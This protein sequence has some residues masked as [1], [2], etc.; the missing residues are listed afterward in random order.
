MADEAIL[1]NEGDKTPN[2]EQEFLS[3]FP[4]ENSL[5]D[6]VSEKE[7]EDE[8]K[9]E[10]KKEDKKPKRD[11]SALVQKKKFRERLEKAKEKISSLEAK[12]ADKQSRGQPTEDEEKELKAQKLLSRMIR[13]ELKAQRE[14]EDEEKEALAD[15]LQEELDD[16]VESSDYTED[17][18]LEV[19][20]EFEVHPDKAVKILNRVKDKKSVEKPKLPQPKGGAET[21]GKED[22]P[23]KDKGKSLFQMA[24][25]I[26]AKMRG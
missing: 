6:K 16:A 14:A 19:M 7:S 20:D 17:D 22:K 18:I 24:Q 5:E 13:D 12:L 10:P 26:K 1:G 3:G 9:K 25:D 15:S 4:D 23:D 21:L 11:S 2:N 8:P